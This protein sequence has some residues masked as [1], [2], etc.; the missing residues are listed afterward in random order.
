MTVSTDGVYWRCL[1]TVPTKGAYWRCLLT[2]P[3]DGAYCRYLLTAPIDNAYWRCLLTVPI[4]SAYWRCLLTVPIDS[5]YWRCLM[6]VPTAQTE[7]CNKI[8]AISLHFFCSPTRWSSAGSGR[9]ALRVVASWYVQVKT[10]PKSPVCAFNW[11][12]LMAKRA[13]VLA[14]QFG[15]FLFLPLQWGQYYLQK[16]SH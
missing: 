1:L 15:L 14:E 7:P 10:E 3:T 6:T 9:S 13:K 8:L 5:V 11:E 16:Q 12:T 4:D 2:V